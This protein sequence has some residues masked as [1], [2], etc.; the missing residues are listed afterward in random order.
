M[1]YVTKVKS[2][3]ETEHLRLIENIMKCISDDKKSLFTEVDVSTKMANDE[4]EK[5]KKALSR[6]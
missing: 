4:R 6:A 1:K 2:S 3:I 5:I